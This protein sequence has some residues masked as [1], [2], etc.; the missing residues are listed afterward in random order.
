[1]TAPNDSS[2]REL[3]ESV[4]LTF[5]ICFDTLKWFLTG[6]VLPEVEFYI[7]NQS[8]RSRAIGCCQDISQKPTKSSISPIGFLSLRVFLLVQ[9][10]VPVAMPPRFPGHPPEMSWTSPKVLPTS[11]KKSFRKVL[12][13]VPPRFPRHPRRFPRGHP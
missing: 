2:R 13:R 4:F 12:T 9:R 11:L 10:A 3:P 7:A 6:L 5:S 1:M 8:G